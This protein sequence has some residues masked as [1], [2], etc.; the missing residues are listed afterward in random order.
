[1]TR[2]RTLTAYLF[3][4]PNL[5]A[6]VA[7]MAVPFGWVLWLSFNR[8][9]ILGAT[10]FVGLHNWIGIF[11]D[12]VAVTAVENTFLYTVMAI[13]SVFAIALFLALMLQRIR[14]LGGVFRSALYFPTLM[15]VVLA[16]LAWT[17]VISPDFGFVNIMLRS[18]HLPVINWL[19]SGFLALLTITGLEVWR[20]IGFW[21]VLFLAALLGIPEEYYEAARI[22]G[23]GQWSLF[24]RVTL[25]LLRPTFLFAIVIATILNLQIFNAVYTLTDGGPVYGTATIVWYIYQSMFVFNRP[26]YGAAL[27]FLLMVVTMVLSLVELRILRRSI[28]A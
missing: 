11:H 4:L 3:L 12:P 21:T 1:M 13:P 24:R 28:R 17:F 27:S 22:D 25:P 26:G 2:R 18:V 6:F 5:I 9:G 23:A 20:G 19:G 14:R 16:A 10:Q 7:F 8:G 15:P